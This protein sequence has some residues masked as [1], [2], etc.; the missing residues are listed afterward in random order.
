MT[1]KLR[2]SCHGSLD[3][4]DAETSRDARQWSSL[5]CN[6]LSMLD[7]LGFNHSTP[8]IRLVSSPLS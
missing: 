4:V 8:V 7:K 5:F 6:L 2:Q 1:G 3:D